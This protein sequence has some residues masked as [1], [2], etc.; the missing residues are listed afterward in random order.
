VVRE[1]PIVVRGA[2][3]FGLKTVAKAMHSHSLIDTSWGDGPTDGLGAMVG[4]WWCDREVRSTGTPMS[5][6]DLMKDIALYNE[7]D[8]KVMMEIVR[9]LR[10]NH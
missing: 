6:I 10:Q 7:V 8:C 1:E 5:D 4:A 2:L 9:H 3:N